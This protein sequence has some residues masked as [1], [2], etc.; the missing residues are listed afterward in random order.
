M[1][2]FKKMIGGREVIFRTNIQSNFPACPKIFDVGI[3]PGGSGPCT[4]WPQAWTRAHELVR[5][6]DEYEAA[7]AAAEAKK[8]VARLARIAKHEAKQKRRGA[9]AKAIKAANVRTA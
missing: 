5:L 9:I 8:E 3:S 7:V 6:R 2:T 4:S 1:F